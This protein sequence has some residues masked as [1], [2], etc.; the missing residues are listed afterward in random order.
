MKPIHSSGIYRRALLS[1]MAA[2]PVL[3]SAPAMAAFN[4]DNVTVHSPRER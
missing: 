4:G 2:L 1:T 3:S